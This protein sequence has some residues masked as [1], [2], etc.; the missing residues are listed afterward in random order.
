MPLKGRSNSETLGGSEVKEL[1]SFPGFVWCGRCRTITQESQAMVPHL[2][3]MSCVSAGFL[4]P[5][6]TPLV[7]G[8]KL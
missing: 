3:L 8:G 5:N 2:P 6:L 4:L 7:K 1:F